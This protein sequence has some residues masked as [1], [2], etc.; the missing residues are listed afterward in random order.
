[1]QL[2][3]VAVL[4]YSA[5]AA[6]GRRA[7][8][9]AALEKAVGADLDP[10]ALRAAIADRAAGWVEAGELG[11]FER[12]RAKAEEGRRLLDRVELDQAEAAFAEAERIYEEALV[13]PGVA[14][15]WSQVALWR[16]VTAFERGQP[17]LARKLF[18]RAVALD[19]STRLTE[20][21]ARP[22]VVR[23]FSESLKPR[24]S[25]KL[26][27]RSSIGAEIW[28][29]G[30]AP[31]AEVTAGEHV[32]VARAADRRPMAVLA[33]DVAGLE[34]EL[35]P[36]IDS[37]LQAL[38]SLKRAPNAAGLAELARARGLDAI[39]VTAAG[40]DAGELA[41]VGERMDAAGC[42]STTAT[43]T[44][45]GGSVELAAASLLERVQ[46][47]TPRCPGAP[48]ALLEAAAIAHPR[49]APLIA[50]EPPIVARKP[51]PRK[52]KIWERPWLWLGL[53]AITTAGVAVGASLGSPSPSYK[54]SADGA[55]FTR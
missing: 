4:V 3:V 42:T 43:V 14:S 19:G 45:R 48:E 32:V 46:R 38:E 29:D 12:G 9:Q 13:W 2:L 36:P 49:P 39:Y 44:L 34:L 41:L 50:V 21:S 53:V 27:V 1:V 22:D 24:P 55:A 35:T 15:L 26:T 7:E 6:G 37:T 30:R 52:K 20:A 54:V 23:A 18:Q 28:V 8:V 5:G 11:F 47:L 16:G 31:T 25:V 40:I 10:H 51:P 33:D 17:Q